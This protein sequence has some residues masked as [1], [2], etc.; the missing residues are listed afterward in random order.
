MLDAHR[1]AMACSSTV[2]RAK[3]LAALTMPGSQPTATADWQQQQ[4]QCQIGKVMT[5]AAA[6]VAVSLVAAQAS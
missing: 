2:A 1:T 6:K 5:K 3:D 4:Q